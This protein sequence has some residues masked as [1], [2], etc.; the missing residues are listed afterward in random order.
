MNKD[1]VKQNQNRIFIA[2]SCITISLGVVVSVFAVPSVFWIIVWFGWLMMGVS[3]V[4][5]RYGLDELYSRAF[6]MKRAFGYATSIIFWP[7][8]PLFK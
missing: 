8:L 1:I 2:I 3:S 7:F 5:K 6:S 4:K